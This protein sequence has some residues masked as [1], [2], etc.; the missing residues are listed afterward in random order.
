MEEE[1]EQ[2]DAAK[3]VLLIL[4]KLA[5]HVSGDSFVH[6]QQHFDCIYSFLGQCTDCAVCCR[7]VTQIGWNVK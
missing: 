4:F 1:E 7:P 5:L 2:Q 3:F 6:L